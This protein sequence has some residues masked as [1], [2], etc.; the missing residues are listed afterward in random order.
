MNLIKQSDVK[1]HLYTGSDL[2]YRLAS[3]GFPGRSR[4][5]DIHRDETSSGRSHFE[6]TRMNET[7]MDNTASLEAIESVEQLS[8]TWRAE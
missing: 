5:E 1:N 3:I 4:F 2:K 6:G 7:A 8:E